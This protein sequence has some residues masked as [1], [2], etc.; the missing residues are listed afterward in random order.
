VHSPS[1]RPG[2]LRSGVLTPFGITEVGTSGRKRRRYRLLVSTPFGIN[3]VGTTSSG[4]AAKIDR[5]LP[6]PSHHR[7]G[8]IDSSLCFPS[9]MDVRNAFRHHEVGTELGLQSRLVA[10]CSILSASQ[11]VG[12]LIRTTTTVP[13]RWVLSLSAHRVALVAREQ[14]PSCSQ[15]SRL[16]ASQSWARYQFVLVAIYHECAHAFGITSVTR[17]LLAVGLH[18]LCS[19]PFGITEWALP[20]GRRR[21]SSSISRAQRLSAHRGGQ[22]Y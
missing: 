8:H 9:D 20:G 19:T 17:R 14:S 18:V 15:C 6:T 2:H 3:L 5:E 1:D 4:W 21:R 7:G 10:G 22:L 16:S 13:S 11:R 12:T